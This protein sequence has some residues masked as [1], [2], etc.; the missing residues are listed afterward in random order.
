MTLTPLQEK[1]L[2]T[3]FT[4][5]SIKVWRFGAL[6]FGRM[7][8]AQNFLVEHR[9]GAAKEAFFPSVVAH[10]IHGAVHF[11]VGVHT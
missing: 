2:L 9:S 11:H 5:G 8:T 7:I 1:T 4:V 6:H 10:V 3:E